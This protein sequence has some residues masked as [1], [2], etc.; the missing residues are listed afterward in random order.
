MGYALGTKCGLQATKSRQ[1]LMTALIGD[2]HITT[3][4]DSE[5]FAYSAAFCP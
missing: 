1:Y 3:L 4:P 2:A 5:A